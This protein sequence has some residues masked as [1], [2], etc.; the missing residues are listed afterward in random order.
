MLE[1]N[2][3][4]FFKEYRFR[5]A[6]TN[7]PYTGEPDSINMAGS[8]TRYY[9]GGRELIPT[10]KKAPKELTDVELFYMSFEANEI[11]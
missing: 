6:D 1:S 10:G 3:P 4:G 11:K 9:K 5:Y 7:E 8:E 2:G